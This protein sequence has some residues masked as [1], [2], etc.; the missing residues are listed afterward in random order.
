MT[1]IHSVEKRIMEA[2]R[3]LAQ[4]Y[5]EY[6]D[7]FNDSRLE[8]VKNSVVLPIARTG[9]NLR[10]S[11]DEMEPILKKLKENGILDED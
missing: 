6:Q 7:N 10:K 4:V 2:I 3:E 8:H 5:Q 11:F 1:D 9:Q